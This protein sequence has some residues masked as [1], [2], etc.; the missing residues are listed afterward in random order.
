MALSLEAVEVAKDRC[1][2]LGGFLFL[3]M[4]DR[5]PDY[6][7]AR[8]ARIVGELTDPACDAARKAAKLAR[9]ASWDLEALRDRVRELEEAVARL[10][11]GVGEPHLRVVG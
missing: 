11:P 1:A 7:R 6:P 9:R 8:L 2:L 3:S 4:L 5:S 10:T